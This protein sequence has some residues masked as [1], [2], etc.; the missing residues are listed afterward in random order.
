MENTPLMLAMASGLAAQQRENNYQISQSIIAAESAEK[1]V[2]NDAKLADAEKKDL[3][4]QSNGWRE[5]ALDRKNEIN[6]QK[7][8]IANLNAEI[9]Q[10]DRDIEE[11]ASELQKCLDRLQDTQ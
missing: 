6:L 3:S 4:E 11:L 2:K 1:K 5:L 7:Q 9:E 10:K 8:Q